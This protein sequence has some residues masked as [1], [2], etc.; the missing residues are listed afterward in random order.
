MYVSLMRI[1]IVL[2]WL[3]LFAFWAVKLFGGNL[4]EIAVQNENFVKL[5]HYIENSWWRYVSSFVTIFVARYLTI[6]AVCQKFGFKGKS[7]I[8]VIISI[9]SIWFVVNFVN[10]EIL[11]TIY[12]YVVIALFG[13]FYQKGYRKLYGLLSVALDFA[14]STLSMITRSVELSLV[15]DYLISHILSIDLYIMYTL[16]YLYFNFIRL[17]KEI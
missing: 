10:V 12:G 4:F 6:A 14:F 15:Y 8:A 16:Y 1:T 3:S 17:K 9:I 2:C 5:S 11:K 13:V 7:L